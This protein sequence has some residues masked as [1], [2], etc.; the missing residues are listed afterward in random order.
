M[1]L[2]VNEILQDANVLGK[3]VAKYA[4]EMADAGVSAS[5]VEGAASDLAEKDKKKKQAVDLVAEKTALQESDYAAGD[6][7]DQ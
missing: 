7:C 3:T 2:V 6:G 4:T 1:A 5:M